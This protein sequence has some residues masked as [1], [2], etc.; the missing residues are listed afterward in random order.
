MK[1]KHELADILNLYGN[2]FMQK[3]KL[4]TY[5]IHVLNSIKQCRTSYYGGHVDKCDECGHI[6][7]SYN[8]C[9]NR[10]CPKCQ[11]LKKEKWIMAR[12]E[13]LLPIKYFHVVFTVPDTLNK[14]FLNN[15]KQMYDLLF[16]TAW[17]VI[18]SFAADKKHL[19]AKTGMT[20]ILHTNG[21]NLSYHPHIHCIVPGGGI[22]DTGNWK[23]TRSNG[24]FLFPVKAM[25]NVYR[26][27]FVSG[28]R[29]FAKEENIKL[30][31]ELTD[32][33]F[34]KEWVVY[35][36]RPFAGVKSVI[37]YLGRYTHRVAIS[38]HRIIDISNGRVKFSIKNYKKGGR[39]EVCDLSAGEFLRRFCMHI[40]PKNFLKI[41]HHGI[42]SN[43]NKKKSLE[44]ARK[45]LKVKAPE[46]KNT[47]WKTIL[48]QKYGIDTNVCPKCKKGKMLQI[49]ELK[50]GQKYYPLE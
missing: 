2:E 4:P 18:K 43:R 17:S 12:E 10:H 9:G 1:P 30:S 3:E 7:V 48:F 22:D 31:K 44:I 13:D 42:L 14:I 21:Q 24:K 28:L 36:K 34:D 8:S 46:R 37:E 16:Q 39:K 33:L 40:L 32:K 23:N 27:R 45:S 41:R 26:A 15:Q 6:R 29:K 25:S 5:K 50:R 35:A 11:G 49:E 20:S 19:G 47:D 38:N